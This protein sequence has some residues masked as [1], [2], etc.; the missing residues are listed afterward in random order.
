[1]KN[2]KVIIV[3]V[4]IF[5]KL[6]SQTDTLFNTLAKLKTVDELAVSKSGNRLFEKIKYYEYIDGKYVTKIESFVLNTK[7]L[8]KIQLKLPE[9]I[10]NVQFSKDENS[11]FYISDS[12]IFTFNYVGNKCNQLT[13]N[14]LNVNKFAINHNNSELLYTVWGEWKQNINYKQ[15]SSAQI[16]YFGNYYSK[17]KLYKQ[18]L[19]DSLSSKIVLEEELHIDEFD[20]SNDCSKIAYVV[21]SNSDFENTNSTLKIYDLEKKESQVVVSE[22]YNLCPKFSPDSKKLAYYSDENKYRWAAP[23]YLIHIYS[24]ASNLDYT[25]SPTPNSF[26]NYWTV[27]N[28]TSDC[29]NIVIIDPYKTQERIFLIPI[30]KKPYQMLM[31]R[32]GIYRH[33]KVLNNKIYY[34]YENSNT[35]EEIY[36]TNIK[37]FYS[38]V[39][40]TWNTQHLQVKHSKSEII[41]WHTSDGTLVEGELIYPVNYKKGSKFPLIVSLHGGPCDA[42][43]QE[44]M[45][46]IWRF[47]PLLFTNEGFGVFKPNFIGSN[48]YGV[49]FR[50]KL[51]GKWSEIDIESIEDGINLLIKNEIVDSSKLF[52]RG[53]SYGGY[54]T[55]AYLTKSNRFKAACSGAGISNLSSFAGTISIDK[56]TTDYLEAFPFT[57]PERYVTQSPIF[58]ANKIN[59]PLLMLHGEN[60]NICTLSQSQELYRW[61]KTLGR[62][63]ELIIYKN[64]GHG[65]TDPELLY[66]FNMRQLDWFK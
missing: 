16:Q 4:F 11:L 56:F 13:K 14:G 66:D 48:G 5:N 39:I 34:T 49:V 62:K 37:T 58:N 32:E 24:L 53:Y 64:H 54:L 63:S 50:Q 18:N 12:K 41:K 23:E 47:T 52:L 51:I 44:Y 6:I 57:N 9:N 19:T 30:N 59:T 3:F 65:I 10:S 8:T 35:P 33:L 7:D 20:W 29:E 40:S 21:K 27:L 28:W 43:T 42:S 61:L 45:G 60:D 31:E 46:K 26:F 2:L 17:C 36:E 25:L 1:M 15:Y 22:G 55:S 38:R